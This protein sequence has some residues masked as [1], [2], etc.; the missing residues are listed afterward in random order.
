MY[1]TGNERVVIT[2]YGE[3]ESSDNRHNHENH[4]CDGNHN[5]NYNSY[6][7]KKAYIF[8]YFGLF[9]S[10]ESSNRSFHFGYGIGLSWGGI[11]M[12]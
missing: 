5:Y 8:K 11:A 1:R 9:R 10:M 6:L 2:T 3:G 4:N 7:Y 12:I